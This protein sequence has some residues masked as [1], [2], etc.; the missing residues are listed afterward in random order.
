MP[1]INGQWLRRHTFPTNEELAGLQTQ[2]ER[3]RWWDKARMEAQQK[4]AEERRIKRRKI[5]EKYDAKI[6]GIQAAIQPWAINTSPQTEKNVTQHM[7]D[8]AERMFG[9]PKKKR[10]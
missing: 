5:I 10:E 9:T 8:L 4:K 3:H 2:R 7:D 1:K 6:S